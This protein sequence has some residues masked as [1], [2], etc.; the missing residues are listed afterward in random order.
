MGGMS[1]KKTAPKLPA[2]P[3]KPA[4][5]DRFA[6]YTEA[7]KKAHDKKRAKSSS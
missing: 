5:K 3:K 6:A 7:L 4:A 2:A 1:V